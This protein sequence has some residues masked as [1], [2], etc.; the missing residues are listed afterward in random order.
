MYIGEI[1][2][3]VILYFVDLQPRYHGD[4]QLFNGK[5]SEKLNTPN[6]IDI[7]LMADVE[8]SDDARIILEKEL[9]LTL[10]NITEEDA[11]LVKELCRAVVLRAARLSACAIAA[12]IILMG[13]ADFGGKV[14]MSTQI[15]MEGEC[16]L[17]LS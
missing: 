4:R 15:G 5:S 16:V 6:S 1:L 8:D 14:E 2:R 10:S 3:L 17:P 7:M 9:G 11:Q 13:R 12:I